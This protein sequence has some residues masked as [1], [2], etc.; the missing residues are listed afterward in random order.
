MITLGKTITVIN[1]SE[2]VGRPLAALLANDGAKTY[3]VDV[4][5]I[6]F[7]NRAQ[8]QVK[9]SVTK[10]DLTLDQ[11][12]PISDIVIAG[13]PRKDYKIA[14]KLLKKDVFAINFSSDHNFT[15]DIF[16]KASIFVPMIGKMTVV[17]LQ[18]NLLRLYDYRRDAAIRFR[19]Y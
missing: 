14:T 8:N 15:D 16:S 12:L 2:V 5:G 3:S 7:Y 4:D 13:V 17:M 1:R 11:V 6:L 18:R 10:T 9:H 19:F